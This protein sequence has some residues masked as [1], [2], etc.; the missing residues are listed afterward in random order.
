MKKLSVGIIG[1]GQRGYD[2]TPLFCSMD[3]L[4]IVSM[5]DIHEDRVQRATSLV[6]EKT[7]KTPAGYTEWEKVIESKP[8]AII[9][10]TGW[11]DHLKIAFAAMKAGISWTGTEASDLSW[12]IPATGIPSVPCA[13]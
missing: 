4:N 13:P 7:G 9:I 2:L 10:I 6:F 1:L 3:N 12:S 11:E 5:C 8:D